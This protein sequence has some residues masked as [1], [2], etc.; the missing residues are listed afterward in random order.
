MKITQFKNPFPHIVLDEVYTDEEL[1]LIW[2]EINFLQKKLVDPIKTG[3]ASE[4]MEENRFQ[5]FAI[6]KTKILKKAQ[7][8]FL[9]S[10]YNP[11]YNISD[12][13]KIIAKIFC[14]DVRQACKKTDLILEQLNYTNYDSS[15]LNHYFDGDYYEPHRDSSII[16][17]I[18][19]FHKTP[20]AYDGGEL[21]FPDHDY[22]LDLKNNQTLIFPS[23]VM[24][25]VKK[26]TT[27]T[28]DKSFGRFSITKFVGYKR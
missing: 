17:I 14:E 7:G 25:G 12:I 4:L 28:D 20:K 9:D 3:V 22:V 5:H 8:I 19:V 26:I 13:L 2:N 23:I 6:Q 21:Y 16:S 1:T 18:N 27:N 10:I 15:L 11:E 24:H